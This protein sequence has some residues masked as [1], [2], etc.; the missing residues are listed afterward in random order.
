[1]KRWLCYL[2]WHDWEDNL[3]HAQRFCM[4]CYKLKER[5]DG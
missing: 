4:R 1:M 3:F 2:G 5:K